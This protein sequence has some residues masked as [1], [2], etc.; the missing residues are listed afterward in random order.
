MTTTML[1]RST[2]ATGTLDKLSM[3]AYPLIRVTT[4]LLLMPHGAQK[5]FGWFGGYGLSGTGAYFGDTLGMQPGILF[6]L[7]AGLIEF[8]GGGR[9][10]LGGCAER[11]CPQRLLLDRWRYRISTH[12][13]PPRSGDRTARG[14]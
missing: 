4:G 11:P 5:L 12:V 13:A 7:I 2:P 6:A 3:L 9:R 14:R 10:L 8:F 1:N